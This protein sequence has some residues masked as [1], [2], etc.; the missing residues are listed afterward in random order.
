MAPM[1][2]LEAMEPVYEVKGAVGMGMWQSQGA[3]AAWEILERCME[4]GRVGWWEEGVVYLLL[5]Y[6]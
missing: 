3:R 5:F 4:G 1:V 6:L 2:G